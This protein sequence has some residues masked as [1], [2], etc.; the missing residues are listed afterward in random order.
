M[1]S[2]RFRVR[3]AWSAVLA[4]ALGVVAVAGISDLSESPASA[5]VS[6]KHTICH[7]TAST[8]NPYRRITVSINAIYSG[9]SGGFKNA[10]HP[11]H[12]NYVFKTYDANSNG[13]LSGAELTSLAAVHPYTNTFFGFPGSRITETNGTVSA[14]TL[15]TFDGN[16]TRTTDNVF[17]SSI[18]YPAQ[19]K[20]WG[21][22]IPHI[23]PTGT[24]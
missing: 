15:V 5:A 6:A 7:R 11:I 3:A 9:N 19:Q 14:V 16:S 8:T 10:K 21:D 12:N 23:H 1:R 17:R 2:M 18:A 20:K 22:I 24:S 4:A 13:I